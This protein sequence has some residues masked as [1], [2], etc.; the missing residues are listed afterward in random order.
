[1]KAKYGVFAGLTGA[2]VVAAGAQAGFVGFQVTEV[3]FSSGYVNADG[4]INASG[5]AEV[6]AAWTGGFSDNWDTYRLWVQVNDAM[7]SVGA[8]SGSAD[9]SIAMILDPGAGGVFFND[10]LAGNTA[11]STGFFAF[12]ANLAFD[13][14]V[15]IGSSDATGSAPSIT[16]PDGIIGDLSG[17]VNGENVGVTTTPV[18]GNGVVSDGMGGFR[19]LLGQFTVQEGSVFSGQGLVSGPG[20]G[21]NFGEFTSEIPA[22]GALAL[23]GVAGI[24]TR[25]RRKA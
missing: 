9:N 7:A 17:P 12:A 15:T 1:M 24:A 19:V 3:D 11:P 16:D 2:L 5:A 18:A 6:G 8:F 22:P 14:Y 25:R 4:S 10:P 23:L 13:T 20:L 21:S